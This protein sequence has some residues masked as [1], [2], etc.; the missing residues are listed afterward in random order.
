MNA[1]LQKPISKPWTLAG[2]MSHWAHSDNETLKEAARDLYRVT[3]PL[4]SRIVRNFER[5][6]R[7]ETNWHIVGSGVR[8]QEQIRAAVRHELEHQ[9]G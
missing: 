5:I 9:L 4:E 3:V 6:R 8:E 1:L 7:Q 2:L